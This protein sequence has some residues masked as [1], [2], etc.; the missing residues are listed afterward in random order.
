M[1]GKPGVVDENIDRPERG[2][3]LGKTGAHPFRIGDVDDDGGGANVVRSEFFRQRFDRVVLVER[4][5]AR[6]KRTEMRVLSMSIYCGQTK[7]RGPGGPLDP[8]FRT[9]LLLAFLCGLSLAHMLTVALIVPVVM[10]VLWQTPELLRSPR[11]VIGSVVAALA[12]LVSY[13]YVYVRG[14]LHPEWWGD[15]HW[16][17]VR[18]WFWAFLSTA[19]GR[20]E[21]NRGFAPG[22]AFWGG[23]FP[24]LIWHELSLPLLILGLLCLAALGAL[25]AI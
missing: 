20:E 8:A 10:V 5:D 15:G 3:E 4:R 16:S 24:E 18:E 7:V 17:S 2:G 1:L 19:Q 13:S 25:E 23:G 12:P 22:R 9:L 14:A 6:A 21:L 11:A